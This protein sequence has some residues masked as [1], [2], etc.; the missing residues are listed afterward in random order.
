MT[1]EMKRQSGGLLFGVE[2][3]LL[4]RIAPN[5]SKFA[6]ADQLTL[7]AL[8]G[9]VVVAVSFILAG[10]NII[11]L[12]LANIG[13]FLHW[14]GDSLDGRAARLRNENRPKYGHFLDHQLDTFSLVIVFLG[15]HLSALTLSPVWIYALISIL[16]IFTHSFLKSSVVDTLE[17]SVGRIGPTEAR[18]G[19]IVLT[20]MIISLNNLLISILG[21]QTSLLDLVGFLVLPGATLMLLRSVYHS[22]WGNSRVPDK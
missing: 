3:R 8:F 22:L 11:W 9:A 1:R 10:Q 6:T 16:L 7:L 15:I 17:L 12:H 4:D 20:L 2:K 5:V 18:I 19:F 21:Y 13:I 14:F